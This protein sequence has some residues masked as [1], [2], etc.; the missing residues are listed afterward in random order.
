[1]DER[2]RRS[3]A[4]ERALRAGDLA[5][6]RAALADPDAYPNAVDGYTGSTV[7]QLALFN[8]SVPTVAAL[9]DDGADPNFEA[10]DGFPALLLVL[11]HRDDDA[12]RVE[13][14]ARLLDHGVATDTRGINDWTALHVAAARGDLAMVRM[15]LAAGADPGVRT[16]IDDLTTPAE[17]ATAAGHDEVAGV[18][19]AAKAG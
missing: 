5:A 8:A 13:I 10:L 15:L 4:L 17:E 1:M 16:R 14:V 19:R 3:V 7:L 6:V 9:L 2:M 12:V 11:L 18:L